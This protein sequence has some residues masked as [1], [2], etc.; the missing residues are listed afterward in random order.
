MANSQSLL[1]SG[2]F[3]L[4]SKTPASREKSLQTGIAAWKKH[5]QGGSHWTTSFT[6]NATVDGAGVQK[7]Y[8]N[9]ETFIKLGYT[10]SS[11]KAVVG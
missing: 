6:G 5:A 3:K 7:D 11:P 8:W 10:N 4:S 9:Y 2:P 1:E